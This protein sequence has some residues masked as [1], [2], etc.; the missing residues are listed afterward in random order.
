[1]RE[2]AMLGAFRLYKSE[3][4]V[5]FS[6]VLIY[7]LL[8]SQVEQVTMR[9]MQCVF[10]LTVSLWLIVA[11]EAARKSK[12]ADYISIMSDE[13]VNYDEESEIENDEEVSRNHTYKSGKNI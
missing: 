13:D 4:V 1:M 5:M 6:L 11:A 2:E 9:G 3:I 10:L 12:R 7:W 8:S